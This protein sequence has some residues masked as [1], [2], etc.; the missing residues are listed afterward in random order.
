MAEQFENCRKF[1]DSK[2]LQ[3]F[4]N[5]EIYLHLKNRSVSFQKS[6]K[7]VRF[8]GF[9]I[10]TRCRFQNLLDIVPFSNYHFQNLSAAIFV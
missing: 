10:F 1:D 3:D 8:Q 6:R 9:R 2:L 5:K 7:V 4:D